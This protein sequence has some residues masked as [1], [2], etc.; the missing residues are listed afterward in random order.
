MNE[1]AVGIP[2]RGGLDGRAVKLSLETVFSLTLASM[3][4]KKNHVCPNVGG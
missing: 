2:F 1:N 3:A 4:S